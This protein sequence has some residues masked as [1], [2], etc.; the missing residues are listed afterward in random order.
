MSVMNFQQIQLGTNVILQLRLNCEFYFFAL[1]DKSMSSS[2][3]KRQF[4]L[5]KIKYDVQQIQ[6]GTSLN[7]LINVFL[8]TICCRQ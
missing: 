6:I 4:Q 7:H 8:R 3:S 1:F 2:R 5:K